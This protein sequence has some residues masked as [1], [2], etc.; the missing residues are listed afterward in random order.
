MRLTA[1]F[2][3]G[4]FG[5]DKTK[6]MRKLLIACLIIAVAA[7]NAAAFLH[8]KKNGRAQE[9]STMVKPLRVQL[10]EAPFVLLPVW[11]KA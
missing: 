10:K 6:A 4:S 11:F 2:A 1:G 9:P 5:A 3:K 7:L 8:G